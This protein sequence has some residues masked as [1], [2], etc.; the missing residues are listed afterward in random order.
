MIF[1]KNISYVIVLKWGGSFS[2]RNKTQSLKGKILIKLST[3]KFA[4]SEKKLDKEIQKTN[5]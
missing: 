1:Q 5:D 4:N 3:Y 2:A